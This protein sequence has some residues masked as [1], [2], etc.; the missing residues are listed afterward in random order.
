MYINF[1][2]TNYNRGMILPKMNHET[3]E[4]SVIFDFHVLPNA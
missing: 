3:S 4:A 1:Q 2:R